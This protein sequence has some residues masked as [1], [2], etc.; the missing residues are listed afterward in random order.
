MEQSRQRPQSRAR[1]WMLFL[2]KAPHGQVKGQQG[3]AL[4]GERFYLYIRKSFLFLIV[5]RE[6]NCSL[7]KPLPEH[8]RISITEG[9]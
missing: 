6:K 8:G 3:Q 9:F 4:P 1:G 2:H 7:D 5:H